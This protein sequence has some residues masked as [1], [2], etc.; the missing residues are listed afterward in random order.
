METDVHY[1][2]RLTVKL[3]LMQMMIRT[4]TAFTA[5]GN[6]VLKA[7]GLLVNQLQPGT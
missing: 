5:N 6:E 1:L 4:L 7:A 3:A 2:W